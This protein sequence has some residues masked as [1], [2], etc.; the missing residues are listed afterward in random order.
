MQIT[1]LSMYKKRDMYYIF[2]TYIIFQVTGKLL[3]FLYLDHIYQAQLEAY[4]KVDT[5]E[6]ACNVLTGGVSFEAV[7]KLYYIK[8]KDLSSNELMMLRDKSLSLCRKRKRNVEDSEEEEE[9][10]DTLLKGGMEILEDINKMKK[11]IT[12]N[13][14]IQTQHAFVTKRTILGLAYMALLY[15]EQYIIQSDF[16]Q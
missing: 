10:N 11:V 4:N 6:M 5:M 1:I 8:T 13:Q 7:R 16:V 15:S 2:H 9:D 3:W 12:R 14:F